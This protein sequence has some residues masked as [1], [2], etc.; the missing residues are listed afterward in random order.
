MSSIGDSFATPPKR[1][2]TPAETN[3]W[4]I[5]FAAKIGAGT[6][7]AVSARIY[8]TL[9][10]T[11]VADAVTS[12]YVDG[13]TPTTVNVT[14]DATDLTPGTA[15]RLE[16]VVTLASGIVASLLTDIVVL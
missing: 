10:R 11:E 12:A 4:A 5:P 13:S 1:W 7:S 2:V 15:Y 14:W 9:T 6:I 8:A 3:I 16:T